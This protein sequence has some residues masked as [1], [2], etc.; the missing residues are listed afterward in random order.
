MY[1]RFVCFASSVRSN[2]KHCSCIG[3]AA[4]VP[5]TLQIEIQKLRTNGREKKKKLNLIQ[6]F[7]LKLYV[8]I[9]R[10][11]K[12]NISF[13]HGCMYTWQTS[14]MYTFIWNSLE[15]I[16]MK[17][18]IIKSILFTYRPVYI[19]AAAMCTNDDIVNRVGFCF[20]TFLLTLCHIHIEFIMFDSRYLLY[21]FM[22]SFT[23][24]K[25]CFSASHFRM[26]FEKTFSL[27]KIEN[28]LYCMRVQISSSIY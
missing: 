23:I 27:W 24:Q 14:R 9:W 17:N 22:H 15:E 4:W 18:A 21:L 28:G 11:K 3:L 12:K 13:F 16:H 8:F 1:N 25:W 26:A 6:I 10:K 2:W 20:T 5:S 19:C 7:A